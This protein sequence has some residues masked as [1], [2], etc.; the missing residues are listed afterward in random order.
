MYLNKQDED[1]LSRYDK[2][3][4][5]GDNY[6]EARESVAECAL[7]GCV[8]Y[9]GDRAFECDGDKILCEYCAEELNEIYL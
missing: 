2:F 4:M 3:L 8:L 6:D 7:C 1:A 9:S 5:A